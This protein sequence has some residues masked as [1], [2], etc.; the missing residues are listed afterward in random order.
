MASAQRPSAHARQTT[1]GRTPCRGYKPDRG[2]EETL[3]I[4]R[5]GLSGRLLDTFVSTNPID[6]MVSIVRDV[7]G[8]IMRWKNGKMACAGCQL[9]FWM[10]N[11][12]PAE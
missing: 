3:T 1:G 12:A 2:L 4:A 10:P 6:S 11:S 8:N 9:V 7:T 5:L